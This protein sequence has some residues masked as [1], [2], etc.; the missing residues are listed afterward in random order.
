MVLNDVEI[1]DLVAEMGLIS[2]FVSSKTG[3]PS[4]G[5][6][7]FGYDLTLSNEFIRFH[8]GVILDP[9]NPD[10][11]EVSRVRCTTLSFIIQP[12]EFVLASTN[13]TI[14]MPDNLIGQICDKSTLARCGIDVKNTVIEPGFKGQVTLEITNNNNVPVRLYPNRGIA[15]ILFLSGNP[16]R[17]PYNESS[18]YQNQVG[19]TLPR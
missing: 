13:E 11:M 10:T 14:I 8:D 9:C 4:W 6:S 1:E 12:K 5:L 19:V 18:K 17:S 7:S 2:P 3:N 15:Q 16:C